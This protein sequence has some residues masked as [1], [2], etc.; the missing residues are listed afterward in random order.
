M[1]YIEDSAFLM[2]RDLVEQCFEQ[3]SEQRKKY[4]NKFT[5][6][7][8]RINGI[9][10]YDLLKRGLAQEWGI[11]TNPVF[12]YNRYGKP[13][14]RDN[15]DIHFNLSHCSQAVACV[16]SQHFV[17]VDVETIKPIDISV[18]NYTCN[19]KEK[20]IIFSSLYPDIEFAKL[21]TQKESYLKMLGIGIN[22]DIRNILQED[23]F[24]NLNYTFGV[25]EK[26][27]Y[28]YCYCEMKDC[29]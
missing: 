2:Q 17:G 19:E 14:L 15:P 21:W 5:V 10:A 24:K 27:Q 9:M 16:I 7:R 3:M 26:K 11:I 28:V 25:N 6:S 8:D 22:N 4:V 20:K 13:F 29:K 18:I 23:T 1:L 12:L